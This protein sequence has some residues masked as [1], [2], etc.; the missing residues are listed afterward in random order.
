[1]SVSFNH[2]PPSLRLPL[3]SAELDGSQAGNLVNQR[4][5]LIAGHPET[6]NASDV[7]TPVQISTGDQARSKY[8]ASSQIAE[9]IDAARGAN[10]FDEVIGVSVAEPSAGNKA[11]G[12]IVVN[13]A[14]TTAGTAP[15]YI[16]GTRIQIGI[17]AS[18][19]VNGVAT[20]IANAITANPLLPITASATTD[21]VTLTAKWKVLTGNTI[22]VRWAYRGLQGGE[23]LPAGLT[24]TITAMS[25]G[26]GAPDTDSMIANMGDDDYESVIL[27][28]SDDATLDDFDDEFAIGGDAGRWG[29]LRQLYGHVYTAHD[30]TSAELTTFG[31]AR[32]GPTMSTFGI[33]GSPTPAYIRSA[34]LG[35]VAHRSLQIDPARPLHT[36]ELPGVLAPAVQD[37]FNAQQNNTLLF[38]GISI[39]DSSDDGT[40]RIKKLITNYQQNAYGTPDDAFLKVNTLATNAYLLRS[41]KHRIES[42]FGRHKLANDGTRYGPG[43]AIATPKSIK[44]EIVAQYG[45]HEYIGLVENIRAFKRNLIVERA[46]NSVNV[47]RVN[48]LYP[49]DLV[50]QL[51]VFAVVN[52]FRLQYAQQANAFAVPVV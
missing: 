2:I 51:D 28:W 50:N 21:T 32:G 46:P 8:G 44:A 10:A 16:R 12:S 47:N 1:M 33:K 48:V 14:P 6:G 49:P 31:T 29:W 41:L 27:P 36:L 25:G 34:V 37:R 30:G 42:R 5:I 17:A 18:D 52:Q 23:A 13:T 26:T 4:R 35:A 45:E 3:V 19:T 22:D 9:M 43:Q 15:L 11:T 7:D 40:V 39:A 20:K 38:K 24:T